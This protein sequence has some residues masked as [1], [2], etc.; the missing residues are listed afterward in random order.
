MVSRLK[1]LFPIGHCDIASHNR[2]HT[3][4]CAT[5]RMRN[6]RPMM[7]LFHEEEAFLRRWM[8]DEV[9]FED[10]RGPAK[11]LQLEH[12]VVSAD[13]AILIAAAMPDIAD[14]E[15]AGIEPPAAPPSWP[16]S[17]ESLSARLA[18]ARTL[19]ARLAPSGE[20]K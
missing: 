6:T 20:I 14:Q 9:H 7:N 4:R 11:T 12:G 2:E 15:A 1:R 16:W 10:G 3:N 17:E 8:Y 5:T 13:L 19:L 18:E